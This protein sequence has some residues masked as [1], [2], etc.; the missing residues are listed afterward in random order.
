MNSIHA[1]SPEVNNS[2]VGRKNVKEER[3]FILEKA[4]VTT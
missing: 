1:I 4:F 3:C 2:Y